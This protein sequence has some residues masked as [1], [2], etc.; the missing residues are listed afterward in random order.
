[1]ILD[2]SRTKTTT[3]KQTTNSPVL[4]RLLL[5]YM[6][7]ADPYPWKVALLASLMGISA[8]CASPMRQFVFYVSTNAG[9]DARNLLNA[10]V[11]RKVCFVVVLCHSNS[12]SV[13]S[14]Q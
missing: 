3:N 9:Y 8:I 5:A 2:V 1:M 7:S 11:C 4:L 14:W 10:I 13:I 12:I 6:D